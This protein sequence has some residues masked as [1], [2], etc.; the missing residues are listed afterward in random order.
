MN[1]AGEDTTGE[2]N[3]GGGDL[4]FGLGYAVTDFFAFNIA[5]AFYGDGVD[6]TSSQYSRSSLGFGDTKVGLLF[7]FDKGN[8]SYGANIFASFPTGQ[9]RSIALEEKDYPF[10]GNTY[11]NNGG[12]FRYFS[13]GGIE[14]GIIGLFSVKSGIMTLALNGGYAERNLGGEL[15]LRDNATYYNAALSFDLGTFVPFIEISGIDYSGK[16]KIFTFLDDSVFGPNPVYITPGV[17]IKLGH[18]NLFLA[19]DIRGWWEGENTY[20]FPTDLTDSANITT[21]FG[22]APLWAGILGFSYCFDFVPEKPKTGIIAG[23][24]TDKKTGYTIPANVSIY[25][26]DFLVSSITVDNSGVYKLEEV[27]PGVYK[28][29]VDAIDYNKFTTDVI[30]KEGLTTTLDVALVPVIKEGTLIVN[31]LEMEKKTPVTAEVT[32]G[33]MTPEK[34]TGKITK[35]LVAGTYKITAIPEDKNYLPFERTVEI[36]ADKTLE[37]DANFVKKEFKIVLPQVYFEIGK[38]EIKLESYPVLDEAAKTIITVLESNPNI[39]IEIQ[40]H[41]DSQGSDATNL[42]LSQ[43]RADA[44]KNYLVNTHKIDAT[45]LIAKGYGETKPI[46]PNTTSKGRAQNRRVEFV[47]IK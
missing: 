6:Y 30:V 11:A 47:I 28:I 18:F 34:V 23:I 1:I 36:K 31:L 2:A 24:I 15:G 22:S 44:V 27:N 29:V 41:T 26:D 10:I 25:K 42:K 39:T 9:D 12:V 7:G 32:I 37:I 13:S 17:N 21:G 35:T 3:V 16:D 46:A 5:T 8:L 33:N 4:Y 19:A 45:R 38:A 43:E 14:L 40:G 20:T